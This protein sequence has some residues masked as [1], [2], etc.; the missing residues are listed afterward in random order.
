MKI[1]VG[2]IQGY[3]TMTA[4]EKLAALESFEYD[5]HSDALQE[6]EKHKDQNKVCYCFHCFPIYLP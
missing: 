5:D 1:D 2:L 3:E 6:L 4:E